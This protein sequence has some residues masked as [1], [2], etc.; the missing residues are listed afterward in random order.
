VA[1]LEELPAR[2]KSQ[3]V[4]AYFGVDLT[5][6]PECESCVKLCYRLPRYPQTQV[7]AEETV[8]ATEFNAQWFMISEAR[9]GSRKLAGYPVL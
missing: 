5:A 2:T 4:G 3:M 7:A 8:S 6:C 9:N 1:V